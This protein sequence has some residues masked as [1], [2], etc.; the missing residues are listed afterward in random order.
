[1]KRLIIGIL[2]ISLILCLFG[3]RK[4]AKTSDN[5]NTVI[6]YYLRK[7]VDFGSEHP[8]IAPERRTE[9]SSGDTLEYLLA[10]FMIG[11]VDDKLY[12]PFPS[13]LRV[14]KI[15]QENGKLVIT[16]NTVLTE[17]TG[18]LLTQICA[19]IAMTC[20]SLTGEETVSICALDSNFILQTVMEFSTSDLFLYDNTPELINGGSE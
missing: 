9:L 2:C 13:G 1:M 5:K 12:S 7:D 8:L 4:E 20:T 18:F 19:C 6:F 10:L 17:V 14:E 3:C 16:F 15:Q 11:P